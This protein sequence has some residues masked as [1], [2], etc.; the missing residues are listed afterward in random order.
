MFSWPIGKNDQS[1]YILFIII[2]PS[3]N[4]YSSP[5]FVSQIAQFLNIPWNFR[6]FS[7]Q[8]AQCGPWGAENCIHRFYLQKIFRPVLICC[9]VL[10]KHKH[11]CVLDGAS[12]KNYHLSWREGK[13]YCRRPQENDWG[14]HEETTFWATAV[15]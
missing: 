7:G 10:Q 6:R 12:E 11:G 14:H 5:K 8:G 3:Y 13:H 9:T 15:Q 2:L 4:K 1:Y